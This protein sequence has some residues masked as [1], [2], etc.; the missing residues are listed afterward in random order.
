M[1][2]LSFSVNLISNLSPS[3]ENTGER[4]STAPKEIEISE[5]ATLN[6]V[7]TKKG[8]T[9]IENIAS[10]DNKYLKKELI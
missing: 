6:S 10:K 7:E 8:E 3:S 4:V 1:S 9:P 2:L 5:D